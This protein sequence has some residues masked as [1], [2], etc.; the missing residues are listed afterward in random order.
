MNA[1][2]DDDRPSIFVP[3]TDAACALPSRQNRFQA[4]KKN[5][6]RNRKHRSRRYRR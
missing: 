3:A 2:M 5:Q 4:T 1:A 6:R